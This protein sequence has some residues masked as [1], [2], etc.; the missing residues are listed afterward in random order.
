LGQDKE[1]AR[2]VREFLAGP[3]RPK[4]KARGRMGFV[5]G[6]PAGANGAGEENGRALPPLV[7][8]ADALNALAQEERWWSDVPAGSILTP[9]PGEMA[10]L[11]HAER[12]AVQADRIGTALR[13]ARE[14]RQIVV[15][16]G[17]Y[18][19]IASPDG[20]AYVLPFATP[21]LATAGTG[22]VL[23]GILVGLLAQ[24]LKPLDAAI[25]GGFLHGL[26]AVEIEENWEQG[27]GTVAS[28]LV[29]ALPAALKRL[30]A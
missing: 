7:I 23:A 21:L 24:G 20:E 17:A 18:T 22:D 9:H 19:V 12:D 28:D 6:E 3:E 1:V 27:A 8:D 5:A 4:Q 30:T 15:L 11:L 16:K 25:A 14:W 29:A 2:F 10:R 26:T 13:A